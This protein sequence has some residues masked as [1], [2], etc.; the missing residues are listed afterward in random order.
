MP[1]RS[2]NLRR[3]ND[4]LPGLFRELALA[5]LAAPRLRAVCGEYAA[6]LSS[7]PGGRRLPWG[8]R[9]G[10]LLRKGLRRAGAQP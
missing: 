6:L 8:L 3:R 4:G 5:Y 9:Y 10:P 1:R 7:S 2:G